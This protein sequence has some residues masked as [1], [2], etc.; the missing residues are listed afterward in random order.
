MQ[1]LE[2]QSALS[3]LREGAIK[4]QAGNIVRTE[5]LS[6]FEQMSITFH[7]KFQNKLKV[8]LLTS[9]VGIMSQRVKVLQ[10][11]C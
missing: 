2:V 1:Q 8:T 7:F 9:F 10:T 3:A 6:L 4:I 11:M 5:I